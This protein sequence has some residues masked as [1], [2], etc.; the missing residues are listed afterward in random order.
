MTSGYLQWASDL[1]ATDELAYYGHCTKGVVGQRLWLIFTSLLD[2]SGD[3]MDDAPITY[4]S[5]IAETEITLVRPFFAVLFP[6]L[7]YVLHT[8]GAKY[9]EAFL[10]PFVRISTPFSGRSNFK[11]T[12]ST[13]C[14]SNP[15]Q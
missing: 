11:P 1:N 7:Y 8:L 5:L 12:S 9:I 3:L 4:M 6:F 2:S 14:I 15:F 13:E 10:I